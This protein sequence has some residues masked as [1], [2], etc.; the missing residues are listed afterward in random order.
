M[1]AAFTLDQ[2]AD[3][4]QDDA[5]FEFKRKKFVDPFE[6]KKAYEV[7][8][9]EQAV[10]ESKNGWLQLEITLEAGGNK[11]KR[12]IMLPIFTEDK[13]SSEDPEKL[14]QM[15]QSA[16]TSL[17]SLLRAVDPEVFSV[18]STIDKSG[19][20]W[21]FYDAEGNEISSEEKKLREK[22]VAKA[23]IATAELLRCDKAS[24]VGQT[25]FYVRTEDARDTTKTYHNFYPAAPDNYELAEIVPF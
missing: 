23:V 1:T 21:T 22:L 12:W 2:L 17:H 25:C 24:L 6:V 18:Y 4:V 10:T 15:K 9:T 14:A 7:T 11:A 5:G 13:Q 20:R 16:G 19:A 3:M 8:I